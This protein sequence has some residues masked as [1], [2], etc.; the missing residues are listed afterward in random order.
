M[1]RKV[2]SAPCFTAPKQKFPLKEAKA[3]YVV[4]L[5]G[6]LWMTETL[7]LA[8]TA[9]LPV[10]LY[11]F[12]D[13]LDAHDVSVLYLSDSNFIFVGSLIMAVAIEA[14]NLHERMALRILLITGSNPRWLMLGFQL[15]SAL[16]SMWISNTATTAMMVPLALAVIRELRLFEE[17][18]LSKPGQTREQLDIMEQIENPL[19]PKR[20][21]SS[22]LNIYKALLLSICYSATI[23]GTGTLIGTGPNIVMTGDLDKLYKGESPI[24]FAT[25]MAFSFPQLILVLLFTWLWLQVLF[26]GFKKPKSQ[27]DTERVHQMLLKRYQRLG[28]LK[29]DE[30]LVLILFIALVLL[31]LFR[32][33]KII[34]GWGSFFPS[35]FVSD[36]TTTMLIAFLLF[37][38]PAENPF[39]PSKNGKE[40][41]TLMTWEHMKQNFSWST[42]LLL[43]GGYAM[44]EGVEE[45]GLADVL[46]YQLGILTRLPQWLFIA[47]SCILTTF[48][49][50]FSSNVATASIFLPL[51]NSIAKRKR[52]NPLLFIIP[53]T[54]SCSYA[55]M[56]PAGTPP[57]AIVFSSKMIRVFDMVKAGVILNAFAVLITLISI[58]TYGWWLFELNDFPLWAE[59]NRTMLHTHS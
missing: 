57:N 11:P 39:R 43:G 31:W 6:C 46:G 15:S 12:F 29:F 51:V 25:W 16:L 33:P 27:Q 20:I 41:R 44:A 7:P 59:Y 8:V 30:R 40:Y 48:I 36:G 4:C 9:L 14:S 22:E 13:I 50:E 5:M 2:D 58:H 47:T 18:E 37:V 42:V 28:P 34:P 3:A 38:L 21:S 23:G 55:F 26:I 32:D 17:T 19:D 10:I 52:V 1:I 49:T 54:Y 56:L 35:G 24:T 45:S 53:T